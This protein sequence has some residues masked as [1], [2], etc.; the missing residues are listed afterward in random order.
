MIVLLQI[1]YIPENINHKFH[2]YFWNLPINLFPNFEIMFPDLFKRGRVHLGYWCGE[3][4]WIMQLNI[5]ESINYNDIKKTILSFR[6]FWINCGKRFK[7]C[8]VI[9]LRWSSI[10]FDHLVEIFLFTI[11]ILNTINILN[12]HYSKLLVML[13]ESIFGDSIQDGE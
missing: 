11:H 8:D 10:C 4:G 1:T 5:A 3:L 12:Y 9:I 7:S 2:K 6:G 13:S